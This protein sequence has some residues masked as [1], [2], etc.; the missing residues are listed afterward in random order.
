MGG[1]I[2]V[3]EKIEEAFALFEKNIKNEIIPRSRIDVYLEVISSIKNQLLFYETNLGKACYL[4]VKQ[5]KELKETKCKL[6]KAYKKLTKKQ[7]KK[8]EGSVNDPQ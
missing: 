3:T 5:S 7:I 6:S 2:K 1:F 4:I 8:I